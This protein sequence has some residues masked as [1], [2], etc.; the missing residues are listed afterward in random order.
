[1]FGTMLVVQVRLRD[2]LKGEKSQL[3]DLFLSAI[4]Y[5]VGRN[6]G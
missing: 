6:E 5:Q 3:F 4:R 1:M 2:I